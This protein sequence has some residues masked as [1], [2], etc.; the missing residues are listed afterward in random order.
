M[1]A[2][3]ED[4]LMILPR[5]AGRITRSAARRQKNGSSS[6]RA[7]ISRHAASVMSS[8][9]LPEGGCAL[10][11][12]RMSSRPKR[13]TTAST[14]RSAS[15]ERLRSPASDSTSRPRRSAMSAYGLTAAS[16][17]SWSATD[18]PSRQNSSV[19]AGPMKWLTLVMRAIFPVSFMGR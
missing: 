16:S 17:R 2:A 1:K 3:A 8:T 6:S 9:G 19:M 18:A 15:P 10:L 4:M 13:A 12:T 11:L 5:P 14:A 7:I